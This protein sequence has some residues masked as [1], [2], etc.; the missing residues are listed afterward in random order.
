MVTTFK[1]DTTE[2]TLIF[3]E[4]NKIV[5]VLALLT[6]IFGLGMIY[7]C[8]KYFFISER[9]LNDSKTVQLN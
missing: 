6:A 4:I 9:S 5:I 3:A 7:Y 2:F 8:R 1:L